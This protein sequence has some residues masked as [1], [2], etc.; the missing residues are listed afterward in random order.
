M[1]IEPPSFGSYLRHLRSG[2]PPAAF[3]PDPAYRTPRPA[4]NRA[5]LA[6]A[7]RTSVGYVQKLE[8]GHADNPS[9]AVVD[10]LA[11]ALGSTS[12]ERQHLHDLAS[13]QRNEHGEQVS[14]QEVTPVQREAADGLHPSLAA[15][16][17][18]AWNV[19]YSNA[20]YRRM[21]RRITEVGNVL[22]W[23][24]YVP[25]SKAVMVEWEH[26]A[27]LT[28]AWLRALMARRPGN[29]LFA[30]ILETLSRSAEFVRMW[31]SQEVILG[32]HKP[33]F[34]VHDLDRGREV[35]LLAQVYPTPDPSQHMQLYLGIPAR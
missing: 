7:A 9:P 35:E 25:E 26:E 31:E 11:D 21:F 14:R 29:P 30:E 20:E 23:F 12:V 3:A 13:P 34:L 2:A 22:T 27:R 17:D 16:V 4:M 6:T 15:Y 8:Q 19:L 1:L 5:E 32:R 10:R 33:H 18:E 24:F 28:V